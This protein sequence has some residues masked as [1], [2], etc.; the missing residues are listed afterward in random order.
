[1]YLGVQ[2]YLRILLKSTPLWSPLQLSLPSSTTLFFFL[3]YILG[4]R[5]LSFSILTLF[6]QLH[7]FFHTLHTVPL[8]FL[9][10]LLLF[11]SSSMLFGISCTI[12]SLLVFQGRILVLDFYRSVPPYLCILHNPHMLLP[13]PVVPFVAQSHIL[14]LPLSSFFFQPQ[15][16]DTPTWSVLFSNT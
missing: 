12:Y 7:L 14:S 5:S 13:S 4:I 1:M 3:P 8:S 16:L 6:L 11:L 2:Y 10:F 15:Y 9:L